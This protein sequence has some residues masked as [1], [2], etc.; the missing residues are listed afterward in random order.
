MSGQRCVISARIIG[1]LH[2]DAPKLKMFMISVSWSDQSEVIVYRSF[3]DFKKFHGQ[4][5]KKF[6]TLSLFQKSDRMIPKFKLKAI[7]SS[8]PQKGFNRS[9]QR[10]RFLESYCAKLLQCDLTVIQSSE[11]TQFFM[12]KDHDLQ[13]DFTKNSFMLVL[14]DGVSGDGGQ[15]GTRQLQSNIT[16]PLITQTYCCVAEYETKD[17]KNRPFKVAMDEK[18]DVLI[19]DP[20]GWW[21]VEN[22]EKRLAWFPA[23]YLELRDQEEDEVQGFPQGA[24]LYCAV[25][26]YSTKEADEVSVVIGSVV[27]VLRKSDN[28]WWLIRFS[29][30][31]GYIPSMYLQPYS[32]PRAGLY[33]MQ[34]KLQ[35]STLTLSQTGVSYPPSDNKESKFQRKSEGDVHAFLHKARSVDVLSDSWAQ[36]PLPIQTDDSTAD[37]TFRKMS[38]ASSVSTYSNYSTSSLGE[39]DLSSSLNLSHISLGFASCLSV[40]PKSSQGSPTPPTVPPRPKTEEILTRCTTM[41][42]KAARATKMRIQSQE[43]SIQ[44]R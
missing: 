5:K 26:T 7:K 19:K 11:V 31:V 10:L 43:E 44:S 36:N 32:N 28:G 30:K 4:L 22:E 6:P 37:K 2:R 41:T 20:A 16:H 3:H 15:D 8:M 14:S 23:P 25:K 18:L 17:T 42:R 1:A 27:E 9:I 39:E 38:T 13:P 21:L 34:K 24:S 40:R 33:S 35:S 29:G 12:P